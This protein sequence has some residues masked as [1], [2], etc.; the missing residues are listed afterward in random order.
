MLD[1]QE[2]HAGRVRVVALDVGAA[3]EPAAVALPH[4][5]DPQILVAQRGRQPP[6]GGQAGV[7]LAGRDDHVVVGEAAVGEAVHLH[8][9]EAAVGEAVGDGGEDGVRA[10]GDVGRV[11][12]LALAGP[13]AGGGRRAVRAGEDQHAA[14]GAAQHADAELLAALV[15]AGVRD[16]HHPAGGPAQVDV[17]AAP[18]AGGLAVLG[19]VGDLGEP[20]PVPPV[21]EGV[22]GVAGLRQRPLGGVL[23]AVDQEA[24]A[25]GG[26]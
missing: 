18:A 13:A 26:R 24:D 12:V 14:G 21:D 16:L 23:L 6:G 10:V 8:G 19:G 9:G 1:V 2:R 5:A 11:R 17:D 7:A 20:V 22:H 3:L 15:G 25:V 4:L